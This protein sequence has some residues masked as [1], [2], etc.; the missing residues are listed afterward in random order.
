MWS[1]LGSWRQLS[2]YTQGTP[3]K[4]AVTTWPA[5][6]NMSPTLLTLCFTKT[7]I[8]RSIK[9]IT[10]VASVLQTQPC[11]GLRAHEETVALRYHRN[12]THKYQSLQHPSDSTN[13]N[14][15]SQCSSINTK[16]TPS[17]PLFPMYKSHAPELSI[18]HPTPYPALSSHLA[19]NVSLLFYNLTYKTACQIVPAYPPPNIPRPGRLRSMYARFTM[20]DVLALSTLSAWGCVFAHGL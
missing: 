20:R 8:V 11:E 12:I 14:L 1:P 18:S 17:S 2:A 9:R 15:E 16:N 5:Q 4:L 19:P 3:G 10:N 13:N 7:S 6:S